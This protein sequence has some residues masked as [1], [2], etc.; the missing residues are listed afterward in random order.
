MQTSV[1]LH[2]IEV[3]VYSTRCMSV[4]IDC[5]SKEQCKNENE[6]E[7][8]KFITITNITHLCLIEYY[9]MI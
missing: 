7:T 9:N 3:R 6:N 8:L 5:F 4:S 1:S 2:F